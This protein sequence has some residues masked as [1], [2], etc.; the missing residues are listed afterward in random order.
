MESLDPKLVEALLASLRE[1]YA[2][3]GWLAVIPVALVALVNVFQLPFVQNLLPES[4]QWDRLKLGPKLGIV[5]A[6]SFAGGLVT[7]LAGGLS[8][9]AAAV[10][11]IGAGIAA[12][13]GHKFMLKPA[14]SALTPAA[15]YVPSQ[16]TAAASIVVPF[17]KEALDAARAA[18]AGSAK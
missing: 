14:A 10:T 12:V 16:L 7:H 13:L 5:F 3:G 8:L 11:A 4:I 17:D 2:M 1:A 6:V 18:R 9:G 15:S